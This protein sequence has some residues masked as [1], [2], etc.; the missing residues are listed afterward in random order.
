MIMISNAGALRATVREA[1]PRSVAL[2]VSQKGPVYW[3][4]NPLF[5]ASVVYCGERLCHSYCPA[6]YETLE[7]KRWKETPESQ[8]EESLVCLFSCPDKCVFMQEWSLTSSLNISGWI[9]IIHITSRLPH[10]IYDLSKC[11]ILI[12]HGTGCISVADSL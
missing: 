12:L 3:R 5:M 9:T 11:F 4:E 1:S 10:R 7:M 8:I 2:F 6:L